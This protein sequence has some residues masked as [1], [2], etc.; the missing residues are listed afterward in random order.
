MKYKSAWSFF[1]KFL[2]CALLI[3]IVYE[4]HEAVHELTQDS[5]SR[6]DFP[7]ESFA[8]IS[9]DLEFPESST[10]ENPTISSKGSGMVIGRT[11]QGHSAVLTAN[12]VCNPPPFT[13][14][15]SIEN[16]GKKITVTDFRGNR[17]DAN[18]IHTNIANDLCILEVVGMDVRA[19]DISSRRSNIGDRVYNVASPMAF[20]SPGMVP[21]FDGYYSGDIFSSQGLDSIYTIAAREGSSGSSVLNSRGQIIGV[22]HSSIPGFHNVAICTTYNE[23]LAFVS[24]FESLY[25]GVLG[26]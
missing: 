25:G 19:V 20:F 15:S 7:Y 6:F 14:M 17:Y 21:L 16:F 3:G 24:E 10:S 13:A 8:F 18:T 9:I 22:V 5:Q 4:T 1:Y 12:H 23:L 26:N 2:L 11:H